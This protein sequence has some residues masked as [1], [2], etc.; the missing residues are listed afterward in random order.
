MSTRDRKLH[1]VLHG[2]CSRRNYRNWLFALVLCSPR[3]AVRNSPRLP[4]SVNYGPRCRKF[5]KSRRCL[6]T[7]IDQD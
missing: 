7:D 2:P 5:L 3:L 4:A 1:R 6:P